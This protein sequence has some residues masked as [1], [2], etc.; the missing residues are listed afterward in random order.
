M[1]FLDEIVHIFSL[2]KEAL[3]SE[4]VNVIISYISYL[5]MNNQNLLQENF[6]KIFDILLPLQKFFSLLKILCLNLL[7][8]QDLKNI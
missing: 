3:G 8:N 2:Q 7:N 4:T 5:E 6:N 1:D